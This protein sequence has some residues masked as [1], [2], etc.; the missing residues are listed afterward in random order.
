MSVSQCQLLEIAR[1][2]GNN[3]KIIIMDEPTAALNNEE[4]ELLFQIIRKL[5]DQGTTIIYISHRMK[6]VFEISDRI[7]VL[8][9]G[10]LSAK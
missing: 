1:A 2:I 3:S 7:T 9:D 8:R 5:N 10:Q 4:A 6:E